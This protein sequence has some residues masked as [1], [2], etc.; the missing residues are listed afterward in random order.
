M[1]NPWGSGSYGIGEYGTGLENVDVFPTG[2][3]ASIS[4]GNETTTAEVNEGWGRVEWGNLAWGDA[5]S[6]QTGSVSAQTAIGAVSTQ[7]DVSV[8]VQGIALSSAIGNET[9]K[10][11]AIVTP[12]GITLSVV[13]GDEATQADAIVTP[14]GVTLSVVTGNETIQADAI[15]APNGTALSTAIGDEIPQADAIVTPSGIALT[16]SI[17][18]T[19]ALTIQGTGLSTGVGLVD[20]QAGGNIFIQ[21]DEHT[22]DTGVVNT[23]IGDEEAFTDVT[24]SPAGIAL[25]I[26]EPEIVVDLNTPVD[27]TGTEII[28]TTGIIDANPDANAIGIGAQTSIGQVTSSANANIDVSGNVLNT[29]IG[30]VISIGNANIDVTGISLATAIGDEEAFTD[31]V[32]GVTGISATYAFGDVVIESKY[33][34]DGIN[35]SGAINSVTIDASAVVTPTGIGLTITAANPNII[36]WAEVDVGTEVTWT[37]V[38]LAA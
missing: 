2:I 24:V 33:S 10:A 16:G 25:A 12:N 20:I 32:V 5:Y 35:L 8:L 37:P 38:D 1:S 4:L 26:A 9:I 34:V 7:I 23:F 17:G 30:Q 3:G 19:E 27:V 13:T 21:V 15:V 11:D 28:S 29:S 6:A 22:L 31:V 36:A 18:E 14:N